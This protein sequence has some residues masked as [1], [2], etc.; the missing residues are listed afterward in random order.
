M[1]KGRGRNAKQSK[2][3]VDLF[4]ISLYLYTREPVYRLNSSTVPNKTK[5]TLVGFKN[6]ASQYDKMVLALLLVKKITE[7]K[8]DKKTSY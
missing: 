7:S 6:S 3:K 4:A 2:A 8:T 5:N 1:L